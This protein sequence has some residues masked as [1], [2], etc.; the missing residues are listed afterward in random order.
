[1]RLYK[2]TYKDRKGRTRESAKWYGEFRDHAQQVRRMPLLTDKAASGEAGRKIERLVALRASGDVPD[3]DLSRW[4][5]S[6]PQQITK[7][8]VE[9]RLVDAT[10][11]AATKTLADH[12]EDYE[13]DLASDGNTPKHA[14]LTHFRAKRVMDGC[15][16]RFQSDVNRDEVKAYL[17]KLR[18]A[19]TIGAK[20]Y[21]YYVRDLKAF[22]KWLV[23]SSRAREN[24]LE[25]LESLG[26]KTIAQDPSAKRRAF[27]TDEI[28][29]LLEATIREPT[30]YG[31]S[32][33]ERSLV[34]RL[35]VETGLRASE[36][37]SLTRVS[38]RLDDK[39]PA[40]FVAGSATK[41]AQSA[42]LPI[43]TKTAELLRGHLKLKLPTAKAFAMPP[44]TDTA[45]MIRADLAAAGIV[46]PEGSAYVL[47]F[48]TL[49]H[50]FVTMLAAS[51]V[52]PKV[53]QDLA[54]HSDINLTLSRYS[55]TVLEQR[56]EAVDRLPDFDKPADS[57]GKTGT[58]DAG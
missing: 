40:V 47:D 52:H 53:A 54:R 41:N 49:R 7:L 19:G 31:M 18:K 22:C 57:E 55:H 46:E 9:W 6:C 20:T 33:L 12:L 13:T 17:S 26:A 21:N 4:L 37:A 32:G 5:M 28:R 34:Y 48:H 36:T 3:L 42:D 35:A 30:R 27:T 56:G 14:A 8:L 15:R 11:I 2:N 16:F 50:T 39:R 58:S 23:R 25:H 24:P 10:R 29:K 1:M 43:R 45:R 44:V 51:G 38:F